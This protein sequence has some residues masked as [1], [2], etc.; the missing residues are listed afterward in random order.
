[1]DYSVYNNVQ[2]KNQEMSGMH[3]NRTKVDQ[4]NKENKIKRQPTH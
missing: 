1:M 3:A 4:K 2:Y